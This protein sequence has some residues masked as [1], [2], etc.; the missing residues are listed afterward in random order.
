MDVRRQLPIIATITFAW[1]GIWA[2]AALVVLAVASI[3]DPAV[4][5]PGDGPAEGSAPFC[6]CHEYPARAPRSP[7]SR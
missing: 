2:A 3:V 7:N 5:D 1:A 6:D 4:I